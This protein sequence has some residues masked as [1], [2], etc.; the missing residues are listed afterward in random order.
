MSGLCQLLSNLADQ[1]ADLFQVEEEDHLLDDVTV[2]QDQEGMKVRYNAHYYP[3]LIFNEPYYQREML[4]TQEPEV[5]AFSSHRNSPYRRLARNL[6]V[7][8][9]DLKVAQAILRRFNMITSVRNLDT[10]T[11]LLKQVAET[12]GLA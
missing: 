7:G 8:A 9:I 6:R 12:Y 5:V 1:S 3:K 10:G 11:L 2:L 4:A